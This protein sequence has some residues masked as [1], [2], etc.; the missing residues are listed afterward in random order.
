[1]FYPVKFYSRLIHGRR[2]SKEYPGMGDF[3]ELREY[4]QWQSARDDPCGFG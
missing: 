2:A 3:T 1:M 4:I